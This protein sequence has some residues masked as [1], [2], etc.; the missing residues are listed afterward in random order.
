MPVFTSSIEVTAD[1]PTIKPSLNLNF[2]R[3]RSLD[4]RITF[5]RASTATYIGR[6]G[7][8]KYAGE[9]EA[10]FDHDPETLESLGLLIE[11][12]RTNIWN[13]SA[14][15]TISSTPVY[16]NWDSAT[17]TANVATA[18]DGTTAAD[19]NTFANA[20][21]TTVRRVSTT[22]GTT[23]TFSIY[24]KKD[25]TSTDTL[26]DYFRFIVCWSNNGTTLT[27]YAFP[28]LVDGQNASDVL[29]D[30][31]KRFSF[32]YTAPAGSVSMEFGI[33]NG[34]AGSSTLSTP[35]SVLCWGA[36][37]EAGT[38][39]TSLIPTSGGQ[40]TRAAD[41]ARITGTSFSNFF[42]T[43]EGTL[44]VQGRTSAGD[45]S[46]YTNQPII[47][48]HNGSTTN[49][50]IMF[51]RDN[52]TLEWNVVDGSF[53]NGS[54]VLLD[55]TT[56]YSGAADYIMCGTYENG[57]PTRA[58]ANGLGADG[59]TVESSGKNDTVNVFNQMDI[60]NELGNRQCSSPIKQVRYY[61]LSL[62]DAQIK[63]LVQ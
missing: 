15:L 53:A 56:S 61:P 42:N 19:R 18:P 35:Y 44:V 57:A 25:P 40:A 60:G 22:A 9:D 34:G 20:T 36:Q 49:R 14:D 10:R 30:E 58:V 62:S 47:S 11:E 51:D 28:D 29:T 12:S 63:T 6:D 24:L 26:L 41:R 43:T 33:S 27:S 2:A 59:T 48:I 55:E 17:R 5:T 50:I 39:P 54:G 32:S 23:Y 8:V 38:F 46:Q 45:S 52:G 13:D 31:W 4:P 16:G 7:L 3:S 21:S 1:Y 37:I